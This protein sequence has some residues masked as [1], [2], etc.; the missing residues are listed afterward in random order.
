MVWIEIAVLAIVFQKAR[1]F[2]VKQTQAMRHLPLEDKTLLTHDL[3]K[4]H[5]TYRPARPDDSL[6]G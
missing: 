5:E 2:E 3:K 6:S 1:L 4:D